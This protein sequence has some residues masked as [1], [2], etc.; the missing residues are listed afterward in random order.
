MKKS[1]TFE[2]YLKI[3]ET[4]KA[5]LNDY[6]RGN[7]DQREKQ[8]SHSAKQQTRSRKIRGRGEYQ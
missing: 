5:L 8:K 7:S 1:R 6:H 3:I 2:K 4:F